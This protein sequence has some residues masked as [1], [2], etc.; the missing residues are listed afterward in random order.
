MSK[1]ALIKLL[2]GVED[3]ATAILAIRQLGRYLSDQAIFNLLCA[4]AVATDNGELRRA[5]LTTLRNRGDDAAARFIQYVRHAHNPRIRQW[6]LVNLAM[7][8]CVTA[9][10]TVVDGLRDRNR[11]V[12][13][14]AT[15]SAGLY[16]EPAILSALED[17]FERHR[18]DLVLECLQQGWRTW[19]ARRWIPDGAFAAPL[20]PAGSMV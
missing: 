18:F 12:R 11:A 2:H 9:Q 8:E 19:W 7:M 5:L 1:F 16:R 17:Y 3:Q 13:R 20:A 4:F 15:A 10:T 6:A 14:A